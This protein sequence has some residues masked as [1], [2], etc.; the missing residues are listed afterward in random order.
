[1]LKANIYIAYLNYNLFIWVKNDFFEHFLFWILISNHH[2]CINRCWPT[3]QFLSCT[4]HIF[5]GIF[6]DQ[7]K[8]IFRMD[9]N[10]IFS[11]ICTIGILQKK[12]ELLISIKFTLTN[13]NRWVF[14]RIR[15]IV[16][17]QQCQDVSASNEIFLLHIK[18]YMLLKLHL[19]SMV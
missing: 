10:A 19:A 8:S 18:W 2:A 15:I 3:E 12:K 14:N 17:L 7:R 4:F 5:D 9:L 16:I 1:M 13:N 11:I 6:V